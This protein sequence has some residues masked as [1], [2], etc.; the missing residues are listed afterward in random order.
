[1]GTWYSQLVFMHFL[2]K[3]VLGG[4]YK[5]AKSRLKTKQPFL[6]KFNLNF[7]PGCE[8]KF[9]KQKKVIVQAECKLFE[10]HAGNIDLENPVSPS[11]SCERH[12]TNAEE[13]H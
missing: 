3:K 2:W 7:F 4:G 10:G 11:P 6:K 5:K 12:W 8:Y 1:M 9:G 13:E